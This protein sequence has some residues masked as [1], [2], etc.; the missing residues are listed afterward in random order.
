[1]VDLAKGHIS[2]LEKLKT[3][4]GFL[5]CNLGTG[6]GYSVLE[7]VEAFEK[8]SGRKIQYKLVGR[9]PGD[10]ATCYADPSLALKELGWSAEFEIED[11]CRDSWNWQ[12]KN[13][14]GF[15]S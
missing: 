10:I 1:M 15:R 2:A 6:R 5:T 4:P 12:S 13:P 3:S 7:M 9:R 14:D 8:I 11:M